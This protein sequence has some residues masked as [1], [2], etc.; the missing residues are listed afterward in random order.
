M[1]FLGINLAAEP[2]SIG[3][4]QNETVHSELTISGSYEFC[5]NL[6]L[7]IDKFCHQSG[8]DINKVEGI[9]ITIGPGSYT[10]LRIGVALA[11]TIGKVLS[12]PVYPIDSL[13]A[14]V[15]PYEKIKGLYLAVMPARK[16]EVNCALFACDKKNIKRI[17][18]NFSWQK[19]LMIEKLKMFKEPI[20]VTGIFSEEL[21]TEIESIEGINI[22]PNIISASYIAKRVYTLYLRKVKGNYNNVFPVYSYKPNGT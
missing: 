2:F 3:L 4:T 6:I 12:I 22:I 19:K 11:K 1:I 10:G 9:G 14:L 16:D 15:F 13:E 21:L 7:E 17:T 18:K 8:I 20:N 5:E